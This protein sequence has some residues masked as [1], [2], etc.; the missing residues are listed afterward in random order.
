VRVLSLRSK[1]LAAWAAGGLGVGV[2]AG[3][4]D[5][6]GG[7]HGSGAAAA[8]EVGAAALIARSDANGEDLEAF[9]GAGLYDSVPA[10]PLAYGPCDY[11]GEPVFWERGAREELARR[12]AAAAAAAAVEAAMGGGAPQDVEGVVDAQGRVMVVQTRP[13]VVERHH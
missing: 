11:S 7:G 4:G 13:Q 10:T 9:A 1:R 8:G 5:G 2:G 6:G 12:V 3:A